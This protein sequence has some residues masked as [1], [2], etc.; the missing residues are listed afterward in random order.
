MERVWERQKMDDRERRDFF[1]KDKIRK[2]I[3]PF[4]L[5]WKCL[6]IVNIIFEG[7][8]NTR[9]TSYDILKHI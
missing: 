3:K 4:I 5:K 9:T 6:R 7:K 1:L 2:G 8:N